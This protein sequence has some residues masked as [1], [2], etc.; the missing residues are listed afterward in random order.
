MHLWWGQSEIYSSCGCCSTIPWGVCVKVV[1]STLNQGMP[2][3]K[4]LGSSQVKHKNLCSKNPRVPSKAEFHNISGLLS[5]LEKTNSSL[6][7]LLLK[8]SLNNGFLW[9]CGLMGV[10]FSVKR[11]ICGRCKRMFSYSL[12]WT[13]LGKLRVVNKSEVWMRF[14]LPLVCQ[15]SLLGQPLLKKAILWKLHLF[16]NTGPGELLRFPG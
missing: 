8:Q 7:L 2:L 3:E 13:H 6:A 4:V 5:S 15:Q 16:T 9:H 11:N 1:S 12:A 14:D 10:A